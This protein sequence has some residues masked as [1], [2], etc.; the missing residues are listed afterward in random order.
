MKRLTKT[1]FSSDKGRELVSLKD[2]DQ[3]HVAVCYCS[4]DELDELA[5]ACNAAA[6]ELRARAP[7]QEQV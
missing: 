4:A 1:V 5:T 7:L 3:G 2:D 6:E